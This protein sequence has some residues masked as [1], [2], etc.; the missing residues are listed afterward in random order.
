LG[1]DRGGGGERL[2]GLFL[3]NRL[4]KKREGRKGEEEEEKK[5]IVAWRGGGKTENQQGVLLTLIKAP[6]VSR[7]R[8]LFRELGQIGKEE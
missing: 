4:K 3:P 6:P 7:S 5:T 2:K 1:R 8:S